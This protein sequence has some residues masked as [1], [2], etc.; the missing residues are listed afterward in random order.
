MNNVSEPPTA[1]P[2]F[3]G[4]AASSNAG[5]PPPFAGGPPPFA[6]GMPPA[7]SNLA[8]NASPNGASGGQKAPPPGLGTVLDDTFGVFKAGWLPLLALCGIGALVDGGLTY[9]SN[10]I[11]LGTAEYILPP[12]RNMV[13]EALY[14]GPA[15]LVWAHVLHRRGSPVPPPADPWPIVFSGLT[16]ARSWSVA[17]AATIL[18]GSLYYFLVCLSAP[19]SAA[20]ALFSLGAGAVVFLMAVQVLLAPV[21]AVSYLAT[22]VAIANPQRGA[23]SSVFTSVGLV[24][25]WPL[26]GFFVLTTLSTAVELLDFTVVVTI[27]IEALLLAY[28]GVLVKRMQESGDAVVEA[29]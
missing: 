26:L 28:T 23:F 19:I 21:V 20:I 10:L 24:A 5:G 1:P 11:S 2:P 17:L 12:L 18:Y 13:I 22:A 6:G 29:T 15:L 14:F 27:P 9:L 25:R 3:N 16:S 7:P 4:S 8:N